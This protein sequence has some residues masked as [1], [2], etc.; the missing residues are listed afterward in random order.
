MTL[1]KNPTFED[2]EREAYEIAQLAKIVQNTESAWSDEQWRKISKAIE[3][4]EQ[5]PDSAR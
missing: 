4:L 3:R 5:K 2:F 1:P